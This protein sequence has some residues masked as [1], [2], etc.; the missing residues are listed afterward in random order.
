MDL[1][2]RFFA[3]VGYVNPLVRLA[4]S[5]SGPVAAEHLAWPGSNRWVE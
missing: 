1:V 2:R 3:A 5:V 4:S